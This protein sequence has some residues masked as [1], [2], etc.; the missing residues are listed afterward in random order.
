MH[1]NVNVR[2]RPLEGGR[3]TPGSQ[4]LVCEDMVNGVDG[5]RPQQRRPAAPQEEVDGSGDSRHPDC[6]STDRGG[7]KGNK[8][9]G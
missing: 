9:D 8:G 5:T 1:T 3:E 6:P 4:S 2:L 7:T